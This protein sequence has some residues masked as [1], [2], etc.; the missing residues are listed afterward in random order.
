MVIKLI[1]IIL[2]P[3][4]MLYKKVDNPHSLKIFRLQYLILGIG[5]PDMR[6]FHQR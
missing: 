3:I 5:S 2:E 1:K 6:R 4:A